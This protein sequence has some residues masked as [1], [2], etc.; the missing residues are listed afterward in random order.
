MST[1]NP[2]ATVDTAVSVVLNDLEIVRAALNAAHHHSTV[3]DLAEQ[4]RKL[5]QRPTPSNLTK[6][7]QSAATIVN[8]YIELATIEDEA[9][10]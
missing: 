6:S 4:Y 1:S 7:L 8:S 9:S 5:I 10:D 2:S 3:I